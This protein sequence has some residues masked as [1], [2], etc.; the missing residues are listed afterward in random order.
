MEF[1]GFFCY[2]FLQKLFGRDI[3]NENKRYR[4]F[5]CVTYLSSDQVES[6]LLKHDRQVKSYAYIVHDKCN[7]EVHLHLL[8]SL[9]NNTTCNAVQNWFAGFEDSN[10][11]QIN[12]LVQP[13]HDIFGSYKYLTHETEQAKEENK[14]V[15]NSDDI[16]GSNLSYFTDTSKQEVDNLT[17]AIDD[18]LNGIPLDEVRKKY[19]RDFIIHYGHIKMLFN[20]I[21]KQYGGTQL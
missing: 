2:T 5:S 16:K 11:S 17:L 10:G 20:D 9:I 14:Y 13:M 18:L 6:V 21:Q 15:Y 3:M 4:N 7:K 19:G 1:I 12:T 8:V